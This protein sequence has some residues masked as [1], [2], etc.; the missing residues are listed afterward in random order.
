MAN[1]PKH[2]SEASPKIAPAVAH[3]K[4]S[5]A[6]ALH[7]RGAFQEAAVLYAE[8]L[9]AYP[10]HPDCLH[11]LGVTAYQGG[12]FARA[13]ALIGKAITVSPNDSFYH[14]NL[15]LALKDLK[16]PADALACFDRAIALQTD[17]TEAHLNRGNTLQDLGRFAE[18]I[19][20][21]DCVIALQPCNP[22]AFN[23]RGIAERELGRCEDAVASHDRAIELHPSFAEAYSNRGLALK[24]LGRTADAIASYDRAIELKPHYA[25]AH[26][27]RGNL[28][29]SLGHINNA[30]A[31]FDRAL[32]LSPG[33]ADAQWNKA[34]ALLLGGDFDRGWPLYEWRWR[35]DTFSSPRR[36]FSQPLW[37]GDSPLAGRTILLHAEQGLGDT[38]QFCR[39]AAIVSAT[40]AR[41][42]L[43]VQPSL[44]SLLSNLEGVS[45]IVPAG[46]PLPAFDV[47]CPLLSL[48]LALSTSLKT[49]P[50]SSPYIQPDPDKVKLWSERLGAR[51]LPR[52]GLVWS[53]ARAHKNDHN[54]S[55]P[56]SGLI[57]YL[58][59][60][61]QYVSL[62]KE[63]RDSDLAL[64]REHPSIHHFGDQIDDFSDTAA[65]CFLMD[66]IVCVDTSVAHLAAALGLPTSV[67]LPFHP[68]WRWLLQ[69]SDSPWYP[70]AT[71][72]RQDAPGTWSAA[73]L[74]VQTQ[75][76]AIGQNHLAN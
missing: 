33:F 42:I 16:L 8:I 5:Q 26:Y 7:Q 29:K 57:P 49:I 66:R 67:L 52:V 56:L 45:S 61:C 73:L 76:T 38:I 51:S 21:Y 43:E 64:L 25:Q 35:M 14:S 4:L 63:V 37:L 28:L 2:R 12:D 69:R 39:F 24:E 74:S 60:N 23:N 11:L 9:A 54:R 68:D 17:Y 72:I 58:P 10:R 32:E 55:I 40:G 59:D 65:L 3:T 27:N 50:A 75:L 6:L 44:L 18:A 47:H 70:S 48:P 46:Q 41:V 30:I 13:A 22:D 31:S 53:G 36:N 1:K 71:L 15:G 20:S 62:Q 34:L 19:A